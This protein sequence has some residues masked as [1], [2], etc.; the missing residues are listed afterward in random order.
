MSVLVAI[1]KASSYQ[2]GL[3]VVACIVYF[4]SAAIHR[5]MTPPLALS[6]RLSHLAVILLLL[7]TGLFL[8]PLRFLLVSLSPVYQFSVI[9][10][11]L[12]VIIHLRSRVE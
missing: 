7:P 10:V 8:V 3:V 1:C 2:L 5:L 12:V 11:S 4:E 9:L 6:L